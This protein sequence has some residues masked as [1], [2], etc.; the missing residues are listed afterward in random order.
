[1]DVKTLY[2]DPDQVRTYTGVRPED[3]GLVDDPPDPEA[4][5]RDEYGA[6]E[7]ETGRYYEIGDLVYT[8]DGEKRWFV[9]ILAHESRTGPPGPDR[10]PPNE[11]YWTEKAEEELELWIAPLNREE[12]LNLV[13]LNWLAH[14]KDLIDQDRGRDYTKEVQDGERDQVPPGIEGIALEMVAR[15]V[16]WAVH[17]RTAPVVRIDDWTVDE[18]RAEILTS[19]I[20][21]RLRRYPFKPRLGLLKTGRPKEV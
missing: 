20:R 7:W 1:M 16:S 18:V 12:K 17:H 2:S 3:L 10:R 14:A 15:M 13:L 8:E 19:D 9:C 4:E 5:D 6:L 11:T 21:A